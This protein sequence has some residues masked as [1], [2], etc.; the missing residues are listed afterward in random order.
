MAY[1][2]LYNKHVNAD[3]VCFTTIGLSLF[4]QNALE[5]EYNLKIVIIWN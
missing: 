1:V 3:A 5:Q 2:S 4:S